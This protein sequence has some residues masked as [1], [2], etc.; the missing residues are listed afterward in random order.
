MKKGLLWTGGGLIALF[1]IVFGLS[2]IGRNNTAITS[3]GEGEGP[4]STATAESAD[5][6]SGDIRCPSGDQEIPDPRPDGPP[7]KKLM[8]YGCIAKA[9]V[10][11]APEKDGEYEAANKGDGTGNALECL[12][13][14]GC[15]ILSR[16]GGNITEH[17]IDWVVNEQL[18]VGCDGGCDKVHHWKFEDGTLTHVKT[19]ESN[20]A[21]A[22][23]G[24]DPE[25]TATPKANLEETND[26]KCRGFGIREGETAT[27]KAGCI[28]S[29]DVYVDGVRLY[30]DEAEIGTVVVLGG[31]GT[32]EVY[33]KYGASVRGA[34]L[35]DII[36]D[37]LHS[38]C[39]FDDGCDE[40]DV[41][42]IPD[43]LGKWKD[44]YGVRN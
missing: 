13:K 36:E 27:V 19:Y 4:T 2:E 28:I 40:I 38:G 21:P 8:E 37:E 43:D 1:A 5:D 42:H 35:E 30:G 33:A 29:G 31:S 25:P 20:T 23:K 6:S 18:T 12:Q 11:V 15:W 39:G 22:A 14:E 16:Y 24:G 10:E 44:R 32:Y 26:T 3:A 9:D 17:D 34:S 41:V 7:V